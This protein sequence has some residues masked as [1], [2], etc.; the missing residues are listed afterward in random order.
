MQVSCADAM[1]IGVISPPAMRWSLIEARALKRI[2]SVFARRTSLRGSPPGNSSR[3]TP[4]SAS[5]RGV[6]VCAAAVGLAAVVPLGPLGPL[7]AGGPRGS[8]SREHPGP[9]PRVPLGSP[10]PPRPAPRPARLQAGGHKRR[11]VEAA[12]GFPA[13]PT[14]RRG[15]ADVVSRLLFELWQGLLPTQPRAR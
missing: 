9:V 2:F 5:G 8:V 13:G 15:A 12:R 6:A 14:R 11:G 4:A 1:F 10:F 7:A 3:L